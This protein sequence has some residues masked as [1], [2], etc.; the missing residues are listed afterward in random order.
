MKSKISKIIDGQYN[1]KIDLNTYLNPSQ[2]TEF[3]S[4]L[5][6]ISK[7][8]NSFTINK[9]G[10]LCSFKNGILTYK[11]ET[12]LPLIHR[13][14]KEKILMVFGNPA[15]HSIKNGMFYFSS[16]HFRRHT[17]WSKLQEAGLMKPVIQKYRFSNVAGVKRLFRPILSEINQM[18]FNRILS[19]PFTKKSTLVVVQKD[20]DEIFT[21]LN[22]SKVKRCI[23]WPAVSRRTGAPKKGSDLA[24]MIT[25]P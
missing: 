8:D 3:E 16:G 24:E 25:E 19:Y 6:D 23:Y 22:T 18:E 10:S 14:N 4:N 15:T 17:M 5:K 7:R 2:I 21:S 1:V 13:S 12:I 11:S 9:S 20:T